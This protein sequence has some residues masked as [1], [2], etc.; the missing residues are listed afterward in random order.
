MSTYINPFLPL[1]PK[2]HSDYQDSLKAYN[3]WKNT[4]DT[5]HEDG[6]DEGFEEGKQ[7]GIQEG[8]EKGRLEGKQEGIQ[9]GNRRG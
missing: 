7:E 6:F 2:E 3:D 1:P 5:A 8:M 9:K 4:L